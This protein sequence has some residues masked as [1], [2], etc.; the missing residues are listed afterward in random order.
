MSLLVDIAIAGVSVSLGYYLVATMLALRF[1]RRLR[2]PIPSLPKIA[3]RV[4][5]LK[6]LHGINESL[7]ANLSS[8]LEIAYPRV[9]YYFGVSDY[10]DRATEVP[11]ALRPRYQYQNMTLVVGEEPGGSNRKI[12]KVIKMAERAEKA[13][14]IAVSDADV[15]VSRDHL[16]RIVGE[17]GEDEKIGAVTCAYRARP[18]GTFASRLEASF[19]NTDFFPQILVSETI[20][21]IQYTMG[22]TMAFKRET[23]HSIGGF[24]SVKDMLADDYFLGQFVSQRGWKIKLS[25]SIVTLTCE[26]QTFADFWKHQLRWARTYRTARPISLF[27]IFTHGPFW[28]IVLMLA[29]LFSPFAIATFAAVIMARVAMSSTISRI[30]KL[31]NPFRD[32]W[33]VLLKDCVMTGIWFASLTSNRV[34]W[35]GREFQ[36]LRGGEMRE[37]GG[38]ETRPERLSA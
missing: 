24:R 20:E 15:E 34:L 21:P 9:E 8:Y 5:V 29:T 2:T 10:E 7:E 13:E 27:T 14:I 37:L 28:G 35:G 22:A 17:F 25:S 3:P 19:A 1:A 11:V 23:L 18:C 12:A 4:A 38:H 33:I 30:L 26:E 36:I 16:R 6:P 31:A 32:S